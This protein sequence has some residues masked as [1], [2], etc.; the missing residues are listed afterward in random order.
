MKDL[1]IRFYGGK[2]SKNAVMEQIKDDLMAYLASNM[3]LEIN[4]KKFFMNKVDAPNV[5][6]NGVILRGMSAWTEQLWQ[7]TLAIQ[8]DMQTAIADGKLAKENSFIKGLEQV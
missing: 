5:E 4:G 1:K 3:S 2:S 8:K 6:V 7:K